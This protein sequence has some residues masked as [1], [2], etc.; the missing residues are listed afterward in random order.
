MSELPVIP[1]GFSFFLFSLRRRASLGTGT[2]GARLPLGT[3]AIWIDCKKRFNEQ[4]EGWCG[5]RQGMDPHLQGIVSLP[6]KGHA[7]WIR[8]A[9][10]PSWLHLRT[11]AEILAVLELELIHPTRSADAGPADSCGRVV[12][13]CR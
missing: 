4:R 6:M 10:R 8:G 3:E 7:S 5:S 9:C 1:R 11:S 13:V 12:G 2:G